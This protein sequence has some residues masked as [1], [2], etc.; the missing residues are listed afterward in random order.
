MQME[1]WVIYAILTLMLLVAAFT[2]IGALTMLVMEKQK[3]VQ[4]LRALGADKGRVQQIFLMEGLLLG[5]MGAIAGGVLGGL[6]CWMQQTF[7]LIPLEGGTFI[8]SHYPVDV[9]TTDVVVIAATVILVTV[10]AAYFPSKRAASNEI[11]LKT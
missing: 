5:G 11:A 9:Q 1:K 6:I 3:D 4:V 8:I 2:L 7:K 10:T